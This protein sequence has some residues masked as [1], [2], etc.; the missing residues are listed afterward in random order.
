MSVDR[1][2]F[3]LAEQA[4]SPASTLL[5]SAKRHS[6]RD[7]FDG[8][9]LDCRWVAPR[10]L[11]EACI[12]LEARPGW[13]TL[14]GNRHTLLDEAPSVFL[15]TR[16]RHHQVAV[17]SRLYFQPQQKD[18]EAG[19]AVR[20]NERGHFT[21]GIRRAGE[22]DLLTVVVSVADQGKST[23][24]ASVP[25]LAAPDIQSGEGV[26][27]RILSD[28]YHFALSY[29]ARPG[30]WVS[31]ARIPA[32]VVSPERNGGFTGA[33]VGMYATSNGAVKEAASFAATPAYFQY[34]CY[35]GL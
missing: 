1:Q 30:N 7:D 3:G 26:E 24:W 31:L 35:D 34:F 20:L 32:Y 33:L 18:E 12:S 9:R 11:C 19:L 13:L 6:W 23:E 22:G 25:L 10:R 16:L 29:A 14:A 4:C 2:P 28:T 15:G 21:L 8:Q 5:A 27:L 17:R